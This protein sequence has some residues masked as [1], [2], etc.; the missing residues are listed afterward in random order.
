MGPK[1]REARLKRFEALCR[2]HGLSMT[3]QRRVI[4]QAVLEREDHPTADQLY[5]LVRDRIPG[6]SR[7]TV[8]RVLETLVR[9]GVVTKVAHPGAAT[10]Y[11]AKIHQHHHLVCLRCDSIVDIE[12]ERL[13]GIELPPV[14]TQGYKIDGFDIHLRGL[15]PECQRAP[16]GQ[17]RGKP[18]VGA[19]TRRAKAVKRRSMERSS[20]DRRKKR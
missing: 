5:G 1:E 2:E 11:D 9:I 6:V 17:K 20:R 13:N 12:D 3:V 18:G 15:C 4:L 14:L 10:R 8:Y 7:T 16:A 19:R